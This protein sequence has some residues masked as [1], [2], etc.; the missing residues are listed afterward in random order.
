MVAQPSD[1]DGL[2]ARGATT[3]VKPSCIEDL[4]Y[5]VEV[6]RRESPLIKL[7]GKGGSKEQPQVKD[8][9]FLQNT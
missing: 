3:I 6:E 1:R 8:Q 2:S 9:G 5:I 7:S 4:G